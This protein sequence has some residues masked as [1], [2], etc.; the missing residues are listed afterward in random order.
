MRPCQAYDA[1]GGARALAATAQALV[2]AK[3]AGLT[4]GDL[5][6]LWPS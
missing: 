6:A 4:A 1:G 2:Q 5:G 3:D